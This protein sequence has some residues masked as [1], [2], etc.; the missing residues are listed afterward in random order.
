MR[1]DYFGMLVPIGS[2]A[3]ERLGIEMNV[4]ADGKLSGRVRDWDDQNLLSFDADWPFFDEKKFTSDITGLGNT[5][6]GTFSPKTGTCRGTVRFEYG[7]RYTFVM[8]R[9]YRVQP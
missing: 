3:N 8:Y 5:V 4:T 9:R 1:G 6:R 7:C 2:C